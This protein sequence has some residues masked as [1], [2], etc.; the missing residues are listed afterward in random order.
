MA[1]PSPSEPLRSAVR[2]NFYLRLTIT[3]APTYRYRAILISNP[4]S[5]GILTI[6]PPAIGDLI[7]LWDQFRKEGGTYRVIER[8]WQHAGWGSISWPYTENRPI[9][10]P[11]LDV[12]VIPFEGPFVQ[13][14]E[15]DDDAE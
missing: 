6:H 15:G 4:E 11:A 5:G 7:G 1:D 3:D 14:A 9:V 8:C 2:C 13:E 12:I 10:G